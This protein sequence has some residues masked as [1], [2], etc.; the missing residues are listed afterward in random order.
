M[1]RAVSVHAIAISGRYYISAAIVF[2]GHRDAHTATLGKFTD[3]ATPMRVKRRHQI[4]QDHVGDVLMK[5]AALAVRP[6]VQLERFTF[7]NALIGDIFNANSREVR[8]ACQRTDGGKLIGFEL[9][10]IAP[11]WV[12]IREGFEMRLR[13]RFTLSKQGQVF[14]IFKRRHIELSLT[15]VAYGGYRYQ[16]IA[17][18]RPVYAIDQCLF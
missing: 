10:R 7:D 9:D 13:D 12:A 4:V 11:I 18:R 5:Y 3:H 6:D 1:V 8:L 15:S 14:Q 2:S 17:L 16:K